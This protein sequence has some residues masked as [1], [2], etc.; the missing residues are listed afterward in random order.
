MGFDDV[1]NGQRAPTI[2]AYVLVKF[3][4]VEKLVAQTYDG[5][6][7]MASEL[8]GVQPKIK[9]KVPEAMF[10]HYKLNLVLMHSAKCMPESRTFFFSQNTGGTRY[11]FQQVHETYPLTGW[12][13]EATFTKSSAHTMEPKLPD[14]ADNRHESIR[15]ACCILY[16]K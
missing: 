3:S 14:A 12:C 13:C 5:A 7:V 15:F 1:S 11:I 16:Y 10:T 9:E 4:C 8:N 2:A 6:A